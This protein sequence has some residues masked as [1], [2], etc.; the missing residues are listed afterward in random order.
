MFICRN[1]LVQPLLNFSVGSNIEA[2][3]QLCSLLMHLHENF[4][5]KSYE[6]PITNNKVKFLSHIFTRNMSKIYLLYKG[7]KLCRFKAVYTKKNYINTI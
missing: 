6:T 7:I 5:L 2:L 4:P 1:A 3:I